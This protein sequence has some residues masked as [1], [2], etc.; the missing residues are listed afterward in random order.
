MIIRDDC[1]RSKRLFENS[2][3]YAFFALIRHR[4]DGTFSQREK[5]EKTASY[6]ASSPF[7][8]G[9]RR[10]KKEFSNSL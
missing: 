4:Y 2:R 7:G 6:L 3:I 10:G 1:V 9:L 8:R 5:E